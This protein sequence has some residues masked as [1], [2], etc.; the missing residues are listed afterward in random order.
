MGTLGLAADKIQ[1]WTRAKG[2]QKVSVGQEHELNATRMLE[3]GQFRTLTV[4]DKI[5]SVKK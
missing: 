1:R 4:V 5:S 2:A 3:R